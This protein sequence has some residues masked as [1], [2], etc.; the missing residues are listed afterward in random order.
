M[1]ITLTLEAL[2]WLMLYQAPGN[3]GQLK[4]DIQLLCAEAFLNA[5][6]SGEKHMLIDFD[7]LQ[8]NNI[9]SKFEYRNGKEE[10]AK[11]INW[12]GLEFPL[13]TIPSV[14]E[15]GDDISR[16]MYDGIKSK[17]QQY[18]D[19][20]FEKEQIDLLLNSYIKRNFYVLINQAAPR[21]NRNGLS[22]IVSAKTIKVAE[23]TLNHAAARLSRTFSQQVFY[24][25]AMH[26]DVLVERARNKEIIS[27]PQLESI[28]ADYPQEY[29]VALE[30]KAMMEEEYSITLPEDEAGFIA[31]FLS[32][33][34]EGDQ[35]AEVGILVIAHGYA[36][37]SSMVDTAN[38]LMGSSYAHAVDMPLNQDVQTTLEQVISKVSQIDKGKGVLLMVDMGSLLAF[39]DIVTE[40]TGIPT[41]VVGMVSTLL[42]M[43]A[44]RKAAIC[45]LEKLYEE[46]ANVKPFIGQ[47]LKNQVVGT[48]LSQK[49]VIVT[50]C[51]TGYGAAQKLAEY[52]RDE[53][54]I[55]GQVEFIPVALTKD[56]NPPEALKSRRIIACVGTVRPNPS[57][58]PYFPLDEILEEKGMGKLEEAIAGSNDHRD[59]IEFASKVVDQYLHNLEFTVVKTAVH[60]AILSFEQ[61]LDIKFSK[62]VVTR[63]F[64]H[65][66]CT[67]DRLAEGNIILECPDREKIIQGDPDKFA[68]IKQQCI[69]LCRQLDLEIPDEEICYIYKIIFEG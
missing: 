44:V 57:Y 13:S 31:I 17:Y 55:G 37:A 28:Q 30:I 56:E 1:P 32:P 24:G 59:I 34:I 60:Q 35:V 11:L 63:L 18:V 12:Q 43:E 7:T 16:Q 21:D 20:G 52:L 50:V 2:I 62:S 14:P 51:V 19:A 61:I 4:N 64:V 42:V 40:R 39:G 67:L 45:P 47:E 9:S 36:T 6:V 25:F 5:V 22:S 66:C 8:H 68:L 58:F 46:V 48:D 27:N 54:S 26:L 65:I 38:R 10:V 29:A 3:V 41:R 69:Y 23:R 15:G 49:P 53:L 33:D